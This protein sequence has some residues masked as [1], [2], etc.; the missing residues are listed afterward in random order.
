MQIRFLLI[1]VLFT[2]LNT[3]FNSNAQA[4][5]GQLL[6]EN[7]EFP[8]TVL[9]GD[10]QIISGTVTNISDQPVLFDYSFGFDFDEIFSDIDFD[11]EY[12]ELIPCDDCDLQPGESKSFSKPVYLNN[13]RV[14]PNKENVII[15]WPSGVIDDGPI[16]GKART[17]TFYVEEESTTNDRNG[18]FVAC[19]SIEINELEG[20]INI[21]GLFD[22][23]ESNIS[24]VNQNHEVIYNC[25]NNCPTDEVLVDIS[26][27]GY[28]LVQA[29]LSSG[30]NF[31]YETKIIFTE[32]W[33]EFEDY[34]NANNFPNYEQLDK[35]FELPNIELPDNFD[36][37][38]QVSECD[39]A[40]NIE[41]NELSIVKP[42]EGSAAVKIKN[43][44]GN[45][46]FECEGETCIN[47]KI[48]LQLP[49]LEEM[50]YT[51]EISYTN[52]NTECNS[53]YSI[54]GGQ[55]V[56]N[57]NNI[58]VDNCSDI[59]LMP[60]PIINSVFSK[61]ALVDI[62]NSFKGF[63]QLKQATAVEWQTINQTLNSY[64]LSQLNACTTYQVRS[65]YNC[66]ETELFSEIQTFTTQGCVACNINDI[67]INVMN[68]FGNTSFISWDI[69][70]GGN[71]LLHYKKQ[72]DNVWNDYKTSI[73]FVML[74]N[75]EKCANYEFFLEIICKDDKVS[76]P[77]EVISLQTGA[78]RL[79]STATTSLEIQPNIANQFINIYLN[80][81]NNS[82]D[83][84]IFNQT[85]VLIKQ[86]DASKIASGAY[87]LDVSALPK[88]I[89]VISTTQN[90]KRYHSKFVK[91]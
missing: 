11:Y 86:I 35:I 88:G 18:E 68:V 39:V 75:L 17:R 66:N 57:N 73:P 55:V 64:L 41:N 60:I 71:Y 37:Q 28:Y 22:A 82:N 85:G 83:L 1:I 20:V 34:I 4:N 9:I 58:P 84:Q 29:N 32:N 16:D 12:D 63:L 78:C 2:L 59:A 80:N 45:I 13:Q 42:L 25:N 23:D 56:F 3:N 51:V 27:N 36:F 91:Q 76:E 52:N 46:V 43:A 26:G 8:D 49:D 65:V 47:N 48:I 30:L 33:F 10:V 61:S 53:T 79:E 44:Q 50:K 70:T 69:F 67:N 21:S 7:I 77:S 74:F 19:N 81:K 89:Y 54:G 40:I 38:N 6:L 5:I 24:V 90:N 15:I 31:C 87:R 72:E 14:A 62:P